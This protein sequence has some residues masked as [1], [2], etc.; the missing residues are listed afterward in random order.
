MD[1]SRREFKRAL[2]DARAKKRQASRILV[3]DV[4]AASTWI[5]YYFR[6]YYFRLIGKFR[7]SSVLACAD[8]LCGTSFLSSERPR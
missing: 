4:I 8:S 5:F 3:C 6:F 2:Y 7:Y 1:N